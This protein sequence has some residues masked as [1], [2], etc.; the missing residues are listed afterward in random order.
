MPRLRVRVLGGLEVEG[1]DHA[2]LGSR[3]QRLLLARLVV[4]QGAVVSVDELAEDLWG[5]GQPTNPR[6]Q[7]AVLASRLRSALPEGC[8][9]RRDAGYALATEWSDVE[10]LTERTIEA[11]RR[12]AGHKWAA[13]AE[14]ARAALAV[15]RGAMLPEFGESD[16]V[17]VEQEAVSL[18]TQQAR[19][20]LAQAELAVGDPRLAA[21]LARDA[22]AASPYDEVALRLHLDACLAAHSPAMGL[23]TYA[24]VRARLADD[25]GAGPSPETRAAYERLL[26]ATDDTG[27]QP[28]PSTA[29]PGREREL[30]LVLR[31]V[32]AAARGRG[33]LVVLTGEAGIGKTHL[34][35]AAAEASRTLVVRARC[36]ELGR[37]LPLQ[38]ILDGLAA[39]LR[40]RTPEELARLLAE[41][42]GLLA[43]LLG[44][45]PPP[46]APGL[47]D[48]GMGQLM[49]QSGVVRLLER[50]AGDGAVLLLVDDAHLADA[51]TVA[52]LTGLPR[53]AVRVAA[54]LAARAGEGPRWPEQSVIEL[55]PLTPEAVAD[56]VGSDRAAVLHAR[57]GG[58]PLLLTELAAHGEDSVPDSLR[59]AFGAAADSAG[60]AGATL[61]AASVV[62]PD[63]DLDVLAQVLHRPAVELLDDLEEG[64]RRRL[65]VE[66]TSGFA[67][68]H[69]LVREALA[70]DVGPTRTALLHR[71]TARALQG[72]RGVDPLVLADHAR[73][74][75]L[76]DVAA[77]AFVEAS[78]IAAARYANEDSLRLADEALRA[79]PAHVAAAL[80]RARALLVLGRYAE[81]AV[82]ADSAAQLGAG[83]P[84]LQVGGLAASYLRDWPLATA[85]ADRAAEDAQDPQDRAI[86]LAIGGHVRHSAGDVAGA[87]AR[88]SAAGEAVRGLGRAPSGWL[89]ILRHHQ[90]RSQET[91]EI[92]LEHGVA[93]GLD[94]LALP[95]VRMS[96]GLSLA[97]LGRCAEALRC[98]TAMDE[99]VAR[100][101]IERY[102]GRADNCR[103]HVL[104]NL[105]FLEEAEEHNLAAR[106]AAAHVGVDEAVAHAV[107]D[108][109]EGRLRVGD[110]DAC[111]RFLDEAGIYTRD[112][113]G[114]GVH[115]RP[116]LR[117]SWLRGRVAVVAG[118]L[119]SALAQAADVMEQARLLQAPRYEALGRV[120]A[121]QVRIAD[122][123][124]PP[125][126]Q[127]LH[128]VEALATYA[129]MEQLWLT[130]DL[131]ALARSDLRQAL[132]AK[133]SEVGGHLIATSPEELQERVRRHVAT[134]L[135]DVRTPG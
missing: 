50:L 9:S 111:Q 14:A 102:A 134:L 97:A 100:L 67:F 92:T 53:R 46:S 13:A 79:R 61:R 106:Q 64:V 131:A 36:D 78:A 94:Q 4:A 47:P 55:G 114:H 113:P 25:L 66:R 135:D 98:F 73:A 84:A 124:S 103:A 39:V 132:L 115:W 8:V 2:A 58:H 1:V 74:G 82:A 108:L 121:L 122:G 76:S 118:D 95:L 3:K 28:A 68:R 18:R 81:A 31:A 59:A 6:D 77:E 16:W 89:A 116:R 125:P 127:G 107:L 120:L 117:A 40:H 101:G 91:L 27:P 123:R 45:A 129:G 104:R 71:Q 60:R 12:A 29:P 51:A 62:G 119:D 109:A 21:D 56:I 130:A 10:A 70:A 34:L 57:S 80:Q 42:R 33:S 41:D 69:A 48:E 87:D 85:L 49:L 110:L 11:A 126:A 20:V 37:V 38:P 105:G 19:L 15:V 96:R 26:Q 54:V 90:G 128:A 83:S 44:F 35:L 7:L 17:V 32:A 30:A 43:P 93:S 63:L 52:L 75:G 88:F 72:S 133:A 86:A 23:T 22:L 99:G 112:A 65:L 5:D 24:A